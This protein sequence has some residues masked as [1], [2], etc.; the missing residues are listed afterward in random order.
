MSSYA[1]NHL[2]YRIS[3][4][5]IR[6]YPYPHFYVE[7]VFPAEFYARIQESFPSAKA[8]PPLKLVREV[9]QNYPSERLCIPLNPEHMEKLPAKDRAF[10]SETAQWLLGPRFFGI[11]MAKF[12][13]FFLERFKKLEDVEFMT[14]ALLVDD[15]TRYWLGPHSDSQKKVLTLLFYLPKDLSQEHLGTSIYVPREPSFR[16]N[17]GPHYAYEDFERMYTAPFRPNT[18]FGFVKTSNSFHG[19]EPLAENESCR[20]QLLLFDINVTAPFALGARRLAKTDAPREA[21]NKP[22]VRF[23]F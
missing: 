7:N 19:V 8:M 13:P 2:A 1:E 6:R 5:E 11:L 15:H 23:S 22:D 16:C 17:G 14:E 21:A 3:N 10:W 4:A 18:L 9:G 12:E 20:R